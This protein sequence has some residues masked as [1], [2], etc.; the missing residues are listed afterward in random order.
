MVYYYLKY[1]L[2]TKRAPK[3]KKLDTKK[4]GKTCMKTT[5]ENI[6]S[7]FEPWISLHNRT[8][9]NEFVRALDGK[10]FMP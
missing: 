7:V 8:Y 6:Y 10:S 3:Q 5:S 1:F 9:K 2:H 4:S